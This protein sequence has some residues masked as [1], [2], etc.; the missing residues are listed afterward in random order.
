M[1]VVNS[2]VVQLLCLFIY[3]L[4]IIKLYSDQH[5]RSDSNM[6]CSLWIILEW[7]AKFPRGGGDLSLPKKRTFRSCGSPLIPGFVTGRL[8]RECR[9]LYHQCFPSAWRII[10]FKDVNPH[11]P[12]HQPIPVVVGHYINR[13]IIE[14]P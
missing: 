6:C 5:W 13:C 11:L 3:Y 1:Q 2:V 12:P 14:H 8:V 7:T 9:G 4:F 10:I